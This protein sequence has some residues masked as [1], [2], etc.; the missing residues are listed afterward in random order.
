[1]DIPLSADSR[2]V[3]YKHLVKIASLLLVFENPFL[4]Y[5]CIRTSAGVAF[6]VIRIIRE[7]LVSFEL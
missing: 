2:A 1:M 3:F 4:L 5:F 7:I 6:R